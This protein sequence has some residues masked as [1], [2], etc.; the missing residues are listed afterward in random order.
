MARGPKP[1]LAFDRRGW[2]GALGVLEDQ[3]RADDLCGLGAVRRLARSMIASGYRIL[4]QGEVEDAD[5]PDLMAPL[6]HHAL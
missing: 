4:P 2:R 6:S 3:P 1:L 5:A